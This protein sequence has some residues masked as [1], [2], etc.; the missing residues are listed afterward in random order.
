MLAKSP[1]QFSIIGMYVAASQATHTILH[2]SLS[3]GQRIQ[4]WPTILSPPLLTVFITLL[5]LF[6]A[7]LHFT[8]DHLL[9]MFIQMKVFIKIKQLSSKK[10]RLQQIEGEKI[11]LKHYNQRQHSSKTATT[12]T[13]A[14][15][16]TITIRTKGR[17]IGHN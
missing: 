3:L 14:I 15:A 5:A 1:V 2:L 6:A 13:I 4:S 7:A 17:F 11:T 12:T 8:S 9:I 16:I 10:K